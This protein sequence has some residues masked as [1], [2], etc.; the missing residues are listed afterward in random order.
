[1]KVGTVV[2]AGA[3]LMV[4]AAPAFAQTGTWVAGVGDDLNPCSRTAPCKTFASAIS[5]TASGGEIRVLD[6]GAY[7]AVTI[8]KP[9]T[10]IGEGTLAAILSTAGGSGIV[11]NLDPATP[12]VVTLRNLH[13]NGV[14]AGLHGIRIT[15]ATGVRVVDCSIKRFTNGILFEGASGHLSVT[16]TEISDNSQSGI[17]FAPTGLAYAALDNVRL[18]GNN[19][20]LNAFANSRI[21]MT[22]SVVAGNT[23]HGLASTATS[24]SGYSFVTVTDTVSSG[25]GGSGF[26]A[27][28]DRGW[29]FIGGVTSTL[30]AVGMTLNSSGQIH[31]WGNNQNRGN[32]SNGAPS[33]PLEPLV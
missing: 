23:S 13:L 31:S 21:S 8:T 19:V 10:I 18:D 11:V 6:A 24:P 27:S 20:G 16:R 33:A 5:K 17:R 12:G 25:N 14:G 7:G 15:N 2:I 26:Y 29:F 1:M 3:F 28:G 32:T 9:I 22:R 30:N 4:A